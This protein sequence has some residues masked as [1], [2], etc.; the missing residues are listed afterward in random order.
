ML[1]GKRC[2]GVSEFWVNVEFFF[3]VFLEVFYGL[4]MLRFS[5]TG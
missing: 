4:I 3:V 5:G 1:Y 2:L